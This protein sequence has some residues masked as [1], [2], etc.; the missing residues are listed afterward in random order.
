MPLLNT[1]FRADTKD[2]LDE[3][4]TWGEEII[5]E[6]TDLFLVSPNIATFLGLTDRDLPQ[7]VGILQVVCEIA[8]TAPSDIV[9]AHSSDLLRVAR[10][11]DNS[12]GFD[13]NAI[14]RKLK[15]KAVAHTGIRL[16]PPRAVP[17]FRKGDAAGMKLIWD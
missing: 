15:T 4:M 11:V 7:A 6:S 13:I 16:L 2:R 17:R 12:K 1:S 3:F 9:Q 10:S 14:V 8:K 5:L